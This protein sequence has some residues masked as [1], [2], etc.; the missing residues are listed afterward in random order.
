MSQCIIIIFEGDKDGGRSCGTLGQLPPRPG[1][2]PAVDQGL[3]GRNP[4]TPRM[5]YYL[6]GE[7]ELV[8]P[9]VHMMR[10]STAV[11]QYDLQHTKR[12]DP[13]GVHT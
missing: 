1:G 2:G 5:R 8:S 7:F 11:Q 4:A 13:L 6:T 12:E 3:F 10:T 9:I